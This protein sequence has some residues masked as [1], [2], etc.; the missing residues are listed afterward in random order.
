MLSSIL[1]RWGICQSEGLPRHERSRDTKRGVASAM[2]P[3]DN[4]N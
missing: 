4:K 1:P 2:K 3:P